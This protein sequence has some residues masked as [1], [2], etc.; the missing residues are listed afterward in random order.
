MMINKIIDISHH[1]GDI[2]FKKVK[3]DGIFGIIHKATQGNRFVDPKFYENREKAEKEGIRV[4]AY[5]FGDGRNP[6]EQVD[7]FLQT[8]GRE[9]TL[10]VLDYEPNPVGTDMTFDQAEEF[11]K[12]F[13]ERTGRYPGLYSGHTIKEDVMSRNLTSPSST[14]L[15]QCWLWMA[16]YGNVIRYPINVWSKWTLWQYTDGKHGPEPHEVNGVGPCD[17]NKFNG[18]SIVELLDFWESNSRKKRGM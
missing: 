17:R 3:Q 9:N 7:H 14:V 4:G 13:F 8:V 2:D 1:N 12:Y 10:L 18:E 15:S 16:Q 6:R 11:V 5:H